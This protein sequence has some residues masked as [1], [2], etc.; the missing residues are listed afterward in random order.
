MAS[1][2]PPQ[3]PQPLWWSQDAGV[4]NIS[5]YPKPEWTGGM[6]VG[7]DRNL[8]RPAIRRGATHLVWR[9]RMFR[10]GSVNGHLKWIAF[11]SRAA[12]RKST[13]LK[14]RRMPKAA[15]LRQ[16]SLSRFTLY[17]RPFLIRFSAAAPLALQP[18][19]SVAALLAR[20]RRANADI[21]CERIRKGIRPARFRLS[22]PA[23][24]CPAASIR[25][26][27]R[28]ITVKISDMPPSANAMR[29]SFIKNGKVVS[30]KSKTYAAWKTAAAWR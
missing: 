15:C 30:A 25:G 7:Y 13:T 6:D 24:A 22:A 9:R 27:G 8:W 5:L 11:I 12:A 3:E 26:G 23:P 10:A 19:I 4:T 28:M 20:D 21:A 1:I 16:A 18:S 29:S 14:G 17:G 2:C